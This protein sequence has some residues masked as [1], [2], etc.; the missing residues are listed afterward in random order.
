MM[1]TLTIIYFRGVEL[2][3]SVA[4]FNPPIPKGIGIKGPQNTGT[5]ELPYQRKFPLKNHDDSWHSPNSKKTPLP[6]THLGEPLLRRKHAHQLH[7]SK[8]GENFR[9]T[10]GRLSSSSGI[11]IEYLQGHLHRIGVKEN[12]DCPLCSTG[13]IMN[14][15]HLTV[16]TTLANT[17]LNVLPPNNY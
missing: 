11:F 17:N 16:C 7:L 10:F 9:V 3:A 6:Q 12:P 14:F 4:Y 2:L 1:Y 15:R 8:G 13:E 5:S